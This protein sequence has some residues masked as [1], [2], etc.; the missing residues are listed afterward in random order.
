LKRIGRDEATKL[1]SSTQA[2]DAVLI[3]RHERSWDWATLSGNEGLPW[4][5]ELIE[6]YE[7]RWAW[8]SWR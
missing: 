7:G 6:R 4:S 2:L 8:W 1:V 3:E 5:L